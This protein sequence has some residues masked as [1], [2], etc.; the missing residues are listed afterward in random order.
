MKFRE[1]MEALTELTGQEHKNLGLV[2]KYDLGFGEGVS[3]VHTCIL[4]TEDDETA[5]KEM[6][7]GL[8]G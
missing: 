5:D 1:A 3:P 7:D 8:M 4:L 2:V 6:S